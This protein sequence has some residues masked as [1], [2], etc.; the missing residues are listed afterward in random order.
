MKQIEIHHV[1]LSHDEL[2]A[3]IF[4][5]AR[6]L[7]VAIP[8]DAKFAISSPRRDEMKVTI[9]WESEQQPVCQDE[10]TSPSP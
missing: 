3:A 5:Y 2:K 9:S 1:V 8:D 7:L 6:D 4:N 10:T